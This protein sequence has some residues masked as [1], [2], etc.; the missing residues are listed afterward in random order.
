MK[1]ISVEE[2]IATCPAKFQSMLR[3]IRECILEIAPDSIE[4]TDYFGI[5]GYSY[6]GYDYDGMFAWFSYKKP[7]I[8]I[9]VRPPV[10]E[11]HKKEF[12]GFKTTKSIVSFSE[13][14]EL[15]VELIKNLI[16]ASIKVMKD[17][18]QKL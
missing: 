1:D 16:A 11:N 14:N 17:T 2:Y 13:D 3:Q 15:P 18:K 7:Y 9:H 6:P 10:I 4:R 12:S 5:P 8:R